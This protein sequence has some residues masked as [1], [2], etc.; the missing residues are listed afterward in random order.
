[1]GRYDRRTAADVELMGERL[2]ERIYATI[3]MVSVTIGL[4]FADPDPAGAALT[5]GATALGLW[6]AALV[7]DQQSYRTLHRHG[8]SPAETRQAL[9][10]SSPLLLSAVGP[11]LLVG[12][13]ALELIELRTALL[14]A[15]AG[16]V[17]TLF[18]WGYVS[19]RR[20]GGGPAVSLVAGAVDM[21][22]GLVVAY[23]KFSA[24]H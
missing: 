6:L 18:F 13:A 15:A 16:D 17:L 7:A 10:V 9:Y 12:V 22:I 4:S 24:G 3:T 2:K 5:V 21:A 8:P 19:G 11:L 23:V 1:M 14:V 20:M